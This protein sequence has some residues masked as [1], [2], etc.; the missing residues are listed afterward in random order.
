[1]NQ[2]TYLFRNFGE[3]I[4]HFNIIG[5][6]KNNLSQFKQNCVIMKPFKVRAGN[7]VTLKMEYLSDSCK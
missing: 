5:L 7:M 2:T 3:C 1:M 4:L 6:I